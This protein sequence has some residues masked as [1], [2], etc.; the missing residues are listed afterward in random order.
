MSSE[1]AGTQRRRT[2]PPGAPAN[3]LSALVGVTVVTEHLMRP[4]GDK[5]YVVED[6]TE[7]YETT[8]VPAAC[9]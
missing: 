6:M 1:I 5:A 2:R 3:D 7:T 8:V 9:P 4:P